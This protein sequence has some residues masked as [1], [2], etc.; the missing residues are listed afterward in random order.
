M[1]TT[2]IARVTGATARAATQAVQVVHQQAPGWLGGLAAGVQAALFSYALV[3]IPLWV[4]TAAADDASLTWSTS[5][6]L[7]ARVW[8]TG[9]AVPWAVDA[10]P[11]SVIP[12]GIP[13]LSAAMV[14]QLAR[15]FASATWGA[16]VV[17]VLTFVATI[18]GICALAWQGAPDSGDRVLRAGVVAAVLA[19]PAVAWGLVRQQG[20]RLP[21]LS[22]VPAPVRAG[23]RLALVMTALL[24][25]TAA[26]VCAASA[27]AHRHVLAQ[28]ATA[29]GPDTVSGIAFAFLETLYAP[30]LVV[31]VVSWLT[32]AGYY[33][34]G[35]DH[36][37]GLS[38]DPD[39]AVPILA[40]LPHGGALASWAP[41]LVVAMGA[42]SA[43]WLR[44]RLGD[45]R[46]ALAGIAVGVGLS[47]LAVGVAAVLA[48][49][50][51][52]PGRYAEVGPHVAPTVALVMA[53]LGGGAILAGVAWHGVA[54]LKESLHP[55]GQ[56][57]PGG[58]PLGNGSPAA[59]SAPSTYSPRTPSRPAQ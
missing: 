6:G 28:S 8:L 15:R 12:L 10:V 24:A 26:L 16:G 13:L 7:A 52:G 45:G 25:G 44:R 51:M 55:S 9:F 43:W 32:G 46:R 41:W 50:S 22:H 17:T 47:A 57:R 29:L 34:A 4:F 21:W 14:S 20:A 59:P 42:V 33:L 18:C 54:L 49:G 38:A 5:T 39:T 53:E 36:L 27:M 58:N 48:G 37:P 2:P 35:V 11:I 31:W 40:S 56:R 1:T 19:I 3:L 30:T 23:T